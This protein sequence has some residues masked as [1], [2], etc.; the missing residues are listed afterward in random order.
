ML[1]GLA[2]THVCLPAPVEPHPG[3]LEA[4]S[5]PWT[6][7]N[8]TTKNRAIATVSMH[9]IRKKKGDKSFNETDISSQECWRQS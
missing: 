8:K 5:L 9:E 3:G 6:R 1:P 7:N 2:D 4:A